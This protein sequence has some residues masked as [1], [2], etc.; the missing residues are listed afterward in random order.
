MNFVKIVLIFLFSISSNAFGIELVYDIYKVDKPAPTIIIG[1]SCGG[2]LTG[3]ETNWARQLNRWGFNAVVLDSFTP[4]KAREVCRLPMQV[5]TWTRADETY[6]MAELIK[7]QPWHQGK[8][9]Y[10]GFS[11]GG[12]TAVYIASDRS[13]KNI[14]AAVAYYPWCGRDYGNREISTASPRINLMLALAKRD[15]WTP[16]GPCMAENKNLEIHLYENAT[17]SFDQHFPG[18]TSTFLG[19]F[20]QHDA[21]A[22]VD[23]RVATRRFFKKYLEGVEESDATA[24]AEFIR[25][26]VLTAPVIDNS[27]SLPDLAEPTEEDLK[28]YEAAEK[29][30]KAKK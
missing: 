17:H 14:D 5:P 26:V 24:R 25:P 3:H 6:K 15:D 22:N 29:K 10:I 28:R 21:Q 9:G 30:T 8:V 1:H 12:S 11:H 20:M 7:K 13:N 4:R 23:S 27:P 2:L 18:W 19:Y 16:Y